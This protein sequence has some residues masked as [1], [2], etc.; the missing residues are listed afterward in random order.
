[1]SSSS[2]KIV[3]FY[4]G[5]IDAFMESAGN[6]G[7]YTN[8]TRVHFARVPCRACPPGSKAIELTEPLRIKSDIKK[9]NP[10]TPNSKSAKGSIV[11]YVH[12]SEMVKET[13]QFLIEKSTIEV[14]YTHDK[15]SEIDF[16]LGMHYDYEFD[17]KT[18][19]PLPRHPLFH[20]QVTNELRALGPYL[21]DD[22]AATISREIY[23][24]ATRIP[25]AHLSFT[26]VLINL[27]ADIFTEVEF[28]KFIAFVRGKTE[29]PKMENQPFSRR[30]EKNMANMRACAWY[31]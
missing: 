14:A 17:S 1:M 24:P 20:A 23:F 22:I 7:V 31:A 9:N 19:E 2:R 4:N 5:L 6:A 16:I 21:K 11:A 12:L 29:F 27:A 10:F 13:N 18:S 8:N 3:S 26:S 15:L 30:V 28:N 25:T